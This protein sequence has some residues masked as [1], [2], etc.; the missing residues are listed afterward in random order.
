MVGR[1]MAGCLT[2]LVVGVMGILSVS[3]LS[4]LHGRGLWCW[5]GASILTGILG[6]CLLAYARLPLYRQGKFLSVGPKELPADRLAA[7][8][9]G[10]RLIVATGCIQVLL[11]LITR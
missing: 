6:V 11:L 10:W 8:R 1:D 3:V 5:F 7:Y 9:W 2:F 4:S